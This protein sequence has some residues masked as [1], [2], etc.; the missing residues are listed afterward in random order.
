[1]SRVYPGAYRVMVVMD[2]TPT[3]DMWGMTEP[4]AYE[5]CQR[6]CAYFGLGMPFEGRRVKRALIVPVVGVHAE[7]PGT[8]FV[9]EGLA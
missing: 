3:S 1:M 2:D 5:D 8:D 4:A 6:A 9:V 7:E